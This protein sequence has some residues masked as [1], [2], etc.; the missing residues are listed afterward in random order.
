MTAT[1]SHLGMKQARESV[2]SRAVVAELSARFEREVVPLL[3]G[4]V[5]QGGPEALPAAG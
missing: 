5:G 2:Q 4:S 1:Q 3:G